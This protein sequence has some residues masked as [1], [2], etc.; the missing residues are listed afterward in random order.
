MPAMAI[1]TGCFRR[2]M[3]ITKNC[4]V[5]I[6]LVKKNRLP[7]DVV[8]DVEH[9]AAEA[10]QNAVNLDDV[11]TALVELADIIAGETEEEE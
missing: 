5:T 1:R 8:A 2:W 3:P 9:A 7:L 10:E 6:M 4:G 11:M